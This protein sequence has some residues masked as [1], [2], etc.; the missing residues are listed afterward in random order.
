MHASKQL[1]GPKEGAKRLYEQHSR[2]E[3]GRVNLGHRGLCEQWLLLTWVRER[4][5]VGD[6]EKELTGLV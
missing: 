6:V 1:T 2:P 3:G 5:D 4:P